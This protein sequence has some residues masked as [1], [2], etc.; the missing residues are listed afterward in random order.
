MD[1]NLISVMVTTYNRADAL[2]AALRALAHQFDPGACW[3]SSDG[4]GVRG[5]GQI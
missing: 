1:T 2:D 4:F 3:H 5:I